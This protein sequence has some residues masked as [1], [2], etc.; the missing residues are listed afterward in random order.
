MSYSANIETKVKSKMTNIM[1]WVGFYRKN[2]HRF[3]EEYLHIELKTFQK[4]LL[5]MMDNNLFFQFW[6]ARGN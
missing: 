5:Y 4:M 6:A 2:V 1:K 3:V